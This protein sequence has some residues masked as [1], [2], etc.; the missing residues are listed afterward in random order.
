MIYIIYNKHDTNMTKQDGDNNCILSYF[1][2]MQSHAPMPLHIKMAWKKYKSLWK[3]EVMNARQFL[4]QEGEICKRIYFIEKGSVRNWLN[5]DGKEISF[6]FFFEG[7]VVYAPESFRKNIPAQFNIETMEPVEARWLG[8][9]EME[10][11]KKDSLLYNFMIEK[12]ADKQAEFMRHFFS[13]LIH[14]P[15][16]RYEILLEKHPEII[17]RVPLQ[18]IAS[19][20]GI[21]AVSLSRIRKRYQTL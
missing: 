15:Q 10:L 17:Q 16:E 11:V 13:Y 3:Y 8:Q 1:R 20:L 9:T 19:Y 4:L 7:D 2:F 5:H 18:Y 6:Q 12:V 21:T 14:T